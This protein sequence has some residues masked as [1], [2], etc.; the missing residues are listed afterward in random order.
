MLDDQTG[1]IVGD[2]GTILKTT[3]GGTSWDPLPSGV[4]S[5]LRGVFFL[6]ADQ[7]YACG[8][9]GTILVTSDG[10]ASWRPQDSQVAT[11]LWKIQFTHAGFVV[12]GEFTGGQGVL[13]TQSTD[14]AVNHRLIFPQFGDGDGFFSQIVLYPF[15]GPIPAQQGEAI[16]ATLHLRQADGNPMSVDLNG[17]E[18]VGGAG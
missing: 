12:G 13:L 2:T 6:D 5:H 9:A 14:P 7:G 18:V 17:A 8:D 10:G 3:N 1:W 16:S 4:S 11:T 15:E